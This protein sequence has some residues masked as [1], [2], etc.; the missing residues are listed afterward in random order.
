MRKK[1]NKLKKRN[2]LGVV[3]D[4]LRTLAP[5]ELRVA[6]GCDTTTVSGFFTCVRS[7]TTD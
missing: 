4:T 2:K 6:A 1:P 5:A 7:C 3:R